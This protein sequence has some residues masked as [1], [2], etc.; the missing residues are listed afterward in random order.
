MGGLSGGSQRS[1]EIRG[2]DHSRGGEPQGM[3]GLPSAG[4]PNL[5]PTVGGVFHKAINVS[6]A[7]GPMPGGLTGGWFIATFRASEKTIIIFAVNLGILPASGYVPLFQDPIA[8]ITV[9]IL[10][11]LATGL[12][13][14]GGADE[15]ARAAFWSSS[16]RIT[17]AP[18]SR[19]VS[20]SASL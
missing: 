5:Y 13:E 19:R 1:A 8:N 15:D 14:V 9:M 4:K 20:P 11:I 10:P 6:L 7:S 3:Q 12:R 17:S 18:P 2:M 16:A